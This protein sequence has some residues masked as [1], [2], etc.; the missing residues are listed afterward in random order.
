MDAKRNAP[1]AESPNAVSFPVSEAA[2]ILERGKAASFRREVSQGAERGARAA[3]A[4]ETRLLTEWSNDSFQD[5]LYVYEPGVVAETTVGGD[6]PFTRL[7]NDYFFYAVLSLRRILARGRT[8]EPK[9]KASAQLL[10]QRSADGCTMEAHT[11][12]GRSCS[13]LIRPCSR[14]SER[15]FNFRTVRADHQRRVAHDFL[16]GPPVVLPTEVPITMGHSAGGFAGDAKGPIYVSLDPPARISG[17]DAAYPEGRLQVDRLG[18]NNLTP[19]VV[20]GA[21][22][23]ALASAGVRVVPE[24]HGKVS[25]LSASDIDAISKYLL[26]LQ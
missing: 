10:G 24:T 9:H 7:A 2:A 1:Y 5:W 15:G 20:D 14:P 12:S 26:S 8:S 18:T 4:T 22:N 13:R 16:G 21:I 23:P 3:I 11:L 19:L 17:P 25:Q 6:G